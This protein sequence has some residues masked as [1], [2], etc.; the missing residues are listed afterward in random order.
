[1]YEC[2]FVDDPQLLVDHWTERVL[3]SIMGSAGANFFY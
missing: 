1:M 3:W 2:R